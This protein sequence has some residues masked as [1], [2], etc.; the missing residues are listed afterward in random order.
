M[1]SITACPFTHN[2]FVS[3]STEDRSLHQI[4]NNFFGKVMNIAVPFTEE[5]TPSVDDV[6]AGL[7]VA[8]STNK[9][10]YTQLI[11]DLQATPKNSLWPDCD[12]PPVTPVSLLWLGAQ[13]YVVKEGTKRKS[14]EINTT[15][16]SASPPTKKSRT[17]GAKNWR[18]YKAI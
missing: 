11:L 1:S 10:V 18:I 5:N 9:H 16:S 3:S 14:P 6:H 17:K 15:I 2:D 7:L 4:A 12:S 13:K 8:S